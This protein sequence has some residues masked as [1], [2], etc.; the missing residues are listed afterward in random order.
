MLRPDRMRGSMVYGYTTT[1]MHEIEYISPIEYTPPL[2]PETYSPYYQYQIL[3][4]LVGQSPRRIPPPS[5]N[6]F[7]SSLNPHRARGQGHAVYS[8]VDHT[9]P[10]LSPLHCPPPRQLVSGH[11][12]SRPSLR[13]TA[14]P[15]SA[16]NTWFLRK[17]PP[18]SR[19][20]A[21]GLCC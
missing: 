18:L 1:V 19:A 15:S 17:P 12:Y 2:R 4:K 14:V 5:R 9:P 20:G 7:A 3:S 11:P 16:R 21:A 8:Y 10:H 13:R 6:A